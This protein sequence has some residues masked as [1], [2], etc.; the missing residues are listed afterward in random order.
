MDGLP[1]IDAG[2]TKRHERPKSD[3]SLPDA[4]PGALQVENDH[5]DPEAGGGVHCLTVG[6]A[7]RAV[8][9]L[10][11]FDLEDVGSKAWMA[12][13][14]AVARPGGTGFHVALP[15]AGFLDS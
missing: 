2:G 15:F 1:R 8:E 6:E 12:Q 3:W 7:E 11:E 14:S 10:R 4:R 9:G 5:R 13:H